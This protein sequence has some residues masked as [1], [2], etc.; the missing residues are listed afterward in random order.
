M[1]KP[2]AREI[3]IYVTS[4][5]DQN[6]FWGQLVLNVS[7]LLKLVHSW[8]IQDLYIC[9]VVLYFFYFF[10]VIFSL[11]VFWYFFKGLF[12]WFACFFDGS[13]FFF[14]LRYKI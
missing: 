7:N 1:K 14:N 12:F 8:H 6:N 4:V 13:W 10:V 2:P 3:V 9:V 11:F 5:F